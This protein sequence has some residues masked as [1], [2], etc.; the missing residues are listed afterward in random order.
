MIDRKFPDK[1]LL[2][3]HQWS[4]DMQPRTYRVVRKVEETPNTTSVYLS[5]DGD[6]PLQPFRAGQHLLFRIPGIGE[7]AYALSAFSPKPKTYRITVKHP[8]R[9]EETGRAADYWRR[10]AVNGDVLEACGPA[11]HFHLP[12]QLERPLVFITAGVGEAPL[13]AIAEEL[14]VRAPRHQLRFFHSTVNGSTFALK[15]KLGSLRGDL[16]N[17]TWRIW[18]DRPQPIDRKDKDFDQHGEIV[19][20]D[21]RAFLPDCD[22]DFYVCGSNG[23]VA[24]VVAELNT[25]GI[26]SLRIHSEQLGR[27]SDDIVDPDERDVLPPVEPRTV[28]FTRSGTSATWKPEHGTLL[29]FAEG[30]GL[31]A[32]YSCRTGMCGKCAQKVLSGETAKV[33]ETPAK[34]RPG[35]Q[36]LC[37]N[38]PISD[39][40][41]D[42]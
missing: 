38:I 33:R 39:L 7:R 20:A 21:L 36:L 2:S 15:G 18:F 13:A 28:H 19:L 24:R 1:K 3:I 9:G 30:L 35:H 16:P 17:A 27:E 34:P 10:Q 5:S 23:F 37:S 32:S 29:E 42:L 11:G 41:I 40:E 31:E 6:A 14:A 25:M 22:C 26:G 12:E 4:W 8:G